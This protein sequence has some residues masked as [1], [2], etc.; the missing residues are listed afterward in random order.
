MCNPSSG[1][2][3]GYFLMLVSSHSLKVMCQYFHNILDNR[4][5]WQIH[6][7]IQLQPWSLLK[8]TSIHRYCMLYLHLSTG[9]PELSLILPHVFF[10]SFSHFRL[11][12]A[13]LSFHQHQML[14]YR[15]VFNKFFHSPQQ[16]ILVTE[17]KSGIKIQ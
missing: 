15:D 11:E 6:T 7:M 17:T 8:P 14:P 5:W 12:I 13:K 4:W 3:V 10:L 1:D 16:R 2:H 9:I